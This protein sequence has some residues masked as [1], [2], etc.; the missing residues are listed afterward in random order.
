VSKLA[1]VMVLEKRVALLS[2]VIGV[3]VGCTCDSGRCGRPVRWFAVAVCAAWAWWRRTVMLFCPIGDR[4]R[5]TAGYLALRYWLSCWVMF[6][7]RMCL[8]CFSLSCFSYELFLVRVGKS[9]SV[10]GFGDWMVCAVAG[11]AFLLRCGG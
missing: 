10:F 1:V 7:L 11:R 8:A 5:P 3:C 2:V 4:G 6:A 9:L